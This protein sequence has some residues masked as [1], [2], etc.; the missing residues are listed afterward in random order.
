MILMCGFRHVSNKLPCS[1]ML[2]PYGY[3]KSSNCPTSGYIAL[4]HYTWRWLL[5]LDSKVW[6]R[7]LCLHVVYNI[8]YFGC[9]CIM[10]YSTCV[11][12]FTFLSVVVGGLR[13]SNMEGACAQ[14]CIMSFSQC[15]WSNGP[16]FSR[17]SSW[18]TM[19]GV[20]ASFRSHH[21]VDLW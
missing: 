21:Y 4:C 2:C 10:C 17:G 8:H 19:Y 12:G 5:A 3:G 11:E 7:R 15:G 20:L 16:I 13:W 1:D 18:I 6:A 9:D 14:L